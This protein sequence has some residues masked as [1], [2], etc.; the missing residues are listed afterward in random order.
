MK[1]GARIFKTGIAIV[2]ALYIAK[3][4]GMTSLYLQELLRFSLLNR[5]SID[6]IYRLWS[7]YKGM[8]S[9]LL[10]QLPSV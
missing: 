6:P 1:L 8:S 10:L 3:L 9:E 7:R 4:V 5:P 2:L